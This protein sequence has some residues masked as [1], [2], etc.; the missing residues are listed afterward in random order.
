MNKWSFMPE[1]FLNKDEAINYAKNILR[2]AGIDLVVKPQ[3]IIQVVT[4]NK[5]HESLGNSVFLVIPPRGKDLQRLQDMC[6]IERNKVV[7][8]IEELRL[9]QEELIKDNEWL[10]EMSS[11]EGNNL[12]TQ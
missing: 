11:N 4:P 2:D 6:S 10:R 8:K 5:I 1:I 12:S 9:A 7:S 3:R